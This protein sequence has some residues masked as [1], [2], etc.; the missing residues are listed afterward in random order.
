MNM[1]AALVKRHIY[2]LSPDDI[3]CTR[4]LLGYG[5]RHPIDNLLYR[6]VKKG[7][8]RRLANG[9]FC[10]HASR[11]RKFSP[12]QIVTAKLKAFGKHFW[13]DDLRMRGPFSGNFVAP[14]KSNNELIVR[15]AGSTS[16][17]TIYTG[18]QITLQGTG[19]RKLKLGKTPAAQ[20]ARSLWDNGKIDL[21]ATHID[22][23]FITCELPRAE[24]I[25]FLLAFNLLPAWLND[26]LYRVRT[27]YFGPALGDLN[28]FSTAVTRVTTK[29]RVKDNVVSLGKQRS[30]LDKRHTRFNGVVPIVYRF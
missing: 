25:E 10:R 17:F 5:E 23:Q 14:A 28:L 26:L 30:I 4:D 7:E 18:M 9:V 21:K 22:E 1:T 20:F 13:H 8:I 15:V 6:L 3:F 19:T 12:M 11:E 24:R 16:S 2:R 29:S 27:R